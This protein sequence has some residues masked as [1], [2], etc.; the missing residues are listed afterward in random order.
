MSTVGHYHTDIGSET[1]ITSQS[2]YKSIMH[3]FDRLCKL[4]RL[5]T[6]LSQTSPPTILMSSSTL[7][8]H[9]IIIIICIQSWSQPVITDHSLNIV[10][11]I[12][13]NH[14]WMHVQ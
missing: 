9:I 8:V 12:S 6:D 3:E 2:L 1:I 14:T 7:S 10:I 13:I 4:L 11:I 5:N